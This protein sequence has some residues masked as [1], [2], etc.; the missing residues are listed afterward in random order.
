MAQQLKMQTNWLIF[1]F[2]GFLSDW[3][4]TRPQRDPNTSS[5]FPWFFTYAVLLWNLLALIMKGRLM[6]IAHSSGTGQEPVF[7]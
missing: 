2:F 5:L 7:D 1:F 3:L 6:V 4:F